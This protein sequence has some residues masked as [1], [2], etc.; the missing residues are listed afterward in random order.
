[1]STLA[2]P[3]APLVSPGPPPARG[4]LTFLA[5]ALLLAGCRDAPTDP[6]VGLVAEDAHAALALGAA[7]PDPVSW[8][9]PGALG[10]AGA[11]ALERWQA[12]WDLPADQ[13]RE[14]RE[15]AYGPLVE[16]L[17]GTLGADGVQGELALLAEAV[18]RAQELGLSVLPAHVSE[19]L[20]RAGSEVVTARTAHLQGDVHGALEAVVRGGDALREVGPEAVARSLQSEVEARLGRVS[21]SDPYSAQDLERLQRLVRGGRQAVEAGD[22]GL[23][24]RR[25]FYAKGLM[26]GNG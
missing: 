20:A 8:A 13:G 23:A 6:M 9:A 24:I 5:V 25:A 14:V 7:F 21:G 1:M 19:G 11:R 3:S 17:A 26:D 16:E 10:E 18:L 4:F 15:S 12:S 2:T 22:W